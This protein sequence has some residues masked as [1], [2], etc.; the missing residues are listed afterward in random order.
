MEVEEV[1]EEIEVAE[2]LV[3][4]GIILEVII[5]GE[6][7][8]GVIEVEEVLVLV[9]ILDVEVIQVGILRAAILE[10]IGEE[11]EADQALVEMIIRAEEALLKEE[12]ILDRFC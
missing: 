1:L 9:E 11:A 7:V 4:V 3:H 12:E 10:V 8:L 2:V 5:L 6:E